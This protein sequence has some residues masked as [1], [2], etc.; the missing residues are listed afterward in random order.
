MSADVALPA[1]PPTTASSTPSSGDSLPPISALPRTPYP[2]AA[3]PDIIRAHQ[4]DAYFTAVL[5][6]QLSDLLR[7]VLG[8]RRAHAWSTTAQTAADA[9]YLSLT[10]L[11][12]GRTLG[13]EYCDLVQVDAGTPTLALPTVARRAAY[14]ACRILLPHAAARLLPGARAR[15]RNMLAAS[16]AR[17][18]AK[19]NT[20]TALYTAQRA[21]LA[22]LPTTQGTALRALFLAAFYFTGAYYTLSQRMLGLRYVFTRR[23][24]SKT[25]DRAGYEVLGVLLLVQ[26]GVQAYLSVER[27]LAAPETSPEIIAAEA[28]VRERVARPAA[29]ASLDHLH[30]YSANNEL[31]PGAA[32]GTGRAAVDLVAVTHTPAVPAGGARLDLDSSKAM[33]WI[34]GAAARKCTLCLEPMRDPAATSCGHV[35][36]WDCIED[37]VREKPECPLCR[38]EALG[39]HIL[40]LRQG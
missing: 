7:R 27:T 32:A 34:R 33:A 8:A 26:L 36:C 14:V 35:F 11:S 10:T 19:G 18:H 23:V 29:A 16:L 28:A 30:S 37:W 21:L 15:L 40:P 3:A 25:A 5:G 22:H 17:A 31:L 1:Q 24:D 2:F 38:R 6:L 20:N 13:E 4:K 12:G 9:L 39:Q